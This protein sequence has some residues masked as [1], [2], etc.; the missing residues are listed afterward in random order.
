MANFSQHVIDN[1]TAH[2][3]L[4]HRVTDPHSMGKIIYIYEAIMRVPRYELWVFRI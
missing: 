1:G 2:K 3:V 4:M